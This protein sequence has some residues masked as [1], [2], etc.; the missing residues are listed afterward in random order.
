M[1]ERMY[2]Q[3]ASH[4]RPQIV[5]H[6]EPFRAAMEVLAPLSRN[7]ATYVRPHC[8]TTH[9]LCLGAG[10]QPSSTRVVMVHGST[11][12]EPVSVVIPDTLCKNEQPPEPNQ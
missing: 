8:V 4:E 5:F 2:P 10:H 1:E 11:Q 7:L 9:Q 3:I 6:M 12:V